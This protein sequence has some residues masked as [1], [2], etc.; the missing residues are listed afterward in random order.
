M[1]TRRKVLQAIGTTTFVS[2]AGSSRAEDDDYEAAIRCI[3]MPSVHH[4]ADKSLPSSVDDC[5]DSLWFATLL[6][7]GVQDANDV[8]PVDALD[9]Q[10]FWVR[11]SSL[12]SSFDLD[13]YYYAG[14][15]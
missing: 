13:Q 3:H 6:H 14:T 11:I 7:D 1:T 9:S 12:Q 4:L 10:V 5:L 8:F 2:A 15:A